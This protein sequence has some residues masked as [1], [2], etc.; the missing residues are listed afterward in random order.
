M[1]T[2][3]LVCRSFPNALLNYCTL[4]SDYP[5]GSIDAIDEVVELFYLTMSL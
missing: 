2:P 3:K 5:G 1:E 4:W